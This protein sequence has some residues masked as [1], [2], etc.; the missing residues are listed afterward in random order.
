MD[1]KPDDWGTFAYGLLASI[2]AICIT[3]LILRAWPR[4]HYP[5]FFAAMAGVASVAAMYVFQ[6]PGAGFALGAVGF[7]LYF[8]MLGGGVFLFEPD[9]DQPASPKAAP[10]AK[11]SGL[12]HI[13]LGSLLGLL[14]SLAGISAVVVPPASLR[15]WVMHRDPL[16]ERVAR[17]LN[18]NK[19]WADLVVRERDALQMQSKLQAENTALSKRATDAETALSKVQDELGTATSNTVRGILVKRGTGSR[20][21]NGLVYIGYRVSYPSGS[22]PAT[23]SSDKTDSIERELKPGEAIRVQTSRGLYRVV[24]VGLADGTCTFDLVKE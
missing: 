17:A 13:A 11:P 18:P 23:V 19:E 6:I 9:N 3:Y 5:R 12:G 24:L 10:R 7:L 4:Q 1:A 15:E 20:H 14:V 2:A 16:H 21:A 8:G 22:C